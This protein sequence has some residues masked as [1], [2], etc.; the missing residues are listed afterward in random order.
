MS[1][2]EVAAEREREETGMANGGC[3]RATSRRRLGSSG[4]RP[5]L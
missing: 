1:A 3:R 2:G 5:S 4:C